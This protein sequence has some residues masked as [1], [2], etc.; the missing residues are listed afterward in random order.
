MGSKHN[1]RLLCLKNGE[2]NPSLSIIQILSPPSLSQRLQKCPFDAIMI[3]NL[4]KD[5]EK[6]T[7][8]RYGANTFKLHRS[9]FQGLCGLCLLNTGRAGMASLCLG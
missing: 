3:I 1:V 7:T 2:N 5:L 8:H 6:E 4:P 9:V